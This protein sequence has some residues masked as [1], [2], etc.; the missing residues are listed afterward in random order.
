MSLSKI[1][2]RFV[3]VFSF[4][5]PLTVFIVLSIVVGLSS[6]GV[7]VTSATKTSGVGGPNTTK[8]IL[9]SPQASSGSF[10][11]PAPL[12]PRWGPGGMNL[13][14]A[15]SRFTTGS[16]HI[17]IA[18]IEGGINWHLGEAKSLVNNIYVN[19]HELPVPC[20][21]E[22]VSTAVMTVNGKR[23]NCSLV[24]SNN[25]ANYD[26]DHDGVINANEW[27]SDPRVHDVNHNGYI[28]PEDLIA[29]FSNN[30]NHDHSGYPNDISGW[31]FYDNQNDPAT[32]DAAYSH[33]DDQM[34]VL[35]AMCPRCMIMPV[36][37]GDE[38]IDTTT[39]LAKAWLFAANQGAKVIVSVTA[40][41]GYSPFMAQ[42]INTLHKRGVVMVEASNDFDSMDHQGGMFW[43]HVLPGNGGVRTSNGLGATVASG[44]PIVY[45]RSDLTSFGP[46]NFL[47][48]LSAGGSTSESTPT[49]GGII[50]LVLSFGQKAYREHLISRPLSGAEAVQILADTATSVT[51]PNLPWPGTPG[52]KWNP[53]YGYGIPNVYAAMEAIAQD[54]IPPVVSIASPDWYRIVNPVTTSELTVT[55]SIHAELPGQ[56]F[57]WVVQA[58][59]GDQP[60]SWFNIGGGSGVGAFTGR[61]AVLKTSLIPKSFWS[62]PFSM[63]NSKFLHTANQY[64]VTLRVEA[65][66]TTSG[67][68]CLP[69]LQP[70]PMTTSLVGISRRV[71]EV[72]Y[73]PTWL[74]GFPYQIGSSGESQPALVNLQS[75]AGGVQDIVFGTS[76]GQIDA[77]NPVTRAELPGWPVHTE[78][79]HVIGPHKGI[80]PGYEPI[81]SDVAVGSL[82]NNG[83]LSVVATTMDGKVYVFNRYGKLRPGWPQS[84][85]GG[86]KSPPI[87]RPELPHVRLPVCGALAAPVLFPLGSANRLDIIQA[88]WDGKIY[89]W[90]PDGAALPGW[91]VAVHRPN[92][93]VLPGEY[94]W[95][96]DHKL[97]STPTIAY[98]QGKNKPPD[99]VERSQFTEI[100]NTSGPQLLPYGWIYA[101]QADGKPL[102]GWPV[103]LPGILEGYGTAMEFVT[104]GTDE[105]VAANVNNNPQGKDYIEAGP[106]WSPPYLINGGGKIVQKYGSFSSTLGGI[107][108]TNSNPL[109]VL[110]GQLPSNVDF[111]FTSSG[112]FGQFGSKLIFAQ[113]M[114][115]APTLVAAETLSGSGY[116]IKNY[117]LAFPA[118]GGS[119][120][121]GFP[122]LAQG[123]DFLGAPIITDVTSS[124]QNAIVGGGDSESLMAFLPNGRQAAGFPKFTGGWSIFSPTSADLLGNGHIDLTL[125]TREGYLFVWKTPG[126][127]PSGKASQSNQWTR[128]HH[129]IWNTGLY[130]VNPAIFFKSLPSNKLASGWLAMLI[131]LA[132]GVVAAGVFGA[133]L[134][135]KTP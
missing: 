8:T 96:A 5:V 74:K 41:L 113:A 86:L 61:L 92:N 3:D 80:N 103:R 121:P 44:M 130:G 27:S 135:K 90:Q 33:S 124:G 72:V 37:A 126:K 36:K 10:Q 105:P 60:T 117:E 108:K 22:T 50:G 98:L 111:P 84:V 78:A 119:A 65:T 129:D 31:D 1:L 55:G 25:F 125:V 49:L 110:K 128:W 14:A 97:E 83:K 35:H 91:P 134:Y 94:T 29:A 57:K 127:A 100:P 20:V 23:E 6:S 85:C 13:T 62:K 53:Q 28:D 40:D 102:P 2:L 54:Q 88:S 131:A 7:I 45:T 34:T 68:P 120:L 114:T 70:A 24:Y 43:P 73:D 132:V 109:A 16:S 17:L 66:L 77:I 11:P 32:V 58:G 46:H 107:I 71:V 104:E 64:N 48:V 75:S 106:I 87:P 4:A 79:V 59:L 19:W 30:M 42:V 133:R 38:A 81:L 93:T 63:S 115:D 67:G 112:A 47:T 89:A 56:S 26:L 39:E 82:Y 9:K 123:L 122:S 15:W 99:I 95:E 51:N 118:K 69:C 76:S 18:Y 12:N 116:G 101:F 52:R 21:G